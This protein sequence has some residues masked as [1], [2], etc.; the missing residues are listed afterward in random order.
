[1][2][3]SSSLRA[4]TAADKE[5]M[6]IGRK[7]SVGAR[8]PLHPPPQLSWR[9]DGA[10]L[11]TIVQ[12]M[13]RQNRLTCLDGNREH[14]RYLDSIARLVSIT[15]HHGSDDLEGGIVKPCQSGN[16]TYGIR[17]EPPVPLERLQGLLH[18]GE[19]RFSQIHGA[20][21]LQQ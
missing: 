17:I 18:L 5:N 13:E 14:T 1:M 8:R 4:Y 19:S 11:E 15:H 16:R 3:C 2:Y 21:H 10:F 20:E 9:R 12:I 6:R 7:I